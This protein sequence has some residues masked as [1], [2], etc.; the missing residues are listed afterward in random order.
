MKFLRMLW[1]TKENNV[2]Y[3]KNIPDFEFTDL[4]SAMHY[5]D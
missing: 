4:L 2:Y 3:K 5:F 1:D